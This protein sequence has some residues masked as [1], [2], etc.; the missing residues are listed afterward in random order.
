MSVI[1]KTEYLTKF[2]AKEHLRALYSNLKAD[3]SLM[4]RVHMLNQFFRKYS[5]KWDGSNAKLGC[6]EI[7]IIYVC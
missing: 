7:S 1:E 3:W 6:G 5:S 2:D 4:F